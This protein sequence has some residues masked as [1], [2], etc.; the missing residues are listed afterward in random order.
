M[1]LAIISNHQNPLVFSCLVHSRFLSFTAS[2]CDWSVSNGL[3]MITVPPQSLNLTIPPL[4]ARTNQIQG[5]R[6]AAN[7]ISPTLPIRFNK[8]LDSIKDVIVG[9]VWMDTVNLQL[10]QRCQPGC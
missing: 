4:K 10:T 3:Q 8:S 6:Q 2:S 7:E 1:Y 5:P 9:D